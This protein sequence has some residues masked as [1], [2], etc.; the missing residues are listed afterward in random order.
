MDVI[1]LYIYCRYTADHWMYSTKEWWISRFFCEAW[2]ICIYSWM[3]II[4]YS[5]RAVAAE[6]T[7]RFPDPQRDSITNLVSNHCTIWSKLL[8]HIDCSYYLC[9]VDSQRST[10]CLLDQKWTREQVVKREREFLAIACLFPYTLFLLTFRQD[11]NH[12]GPIIPIVI[13]SSY[14]I[15]DGTQC[16][17]LGKQ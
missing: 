12:D 10:L 8:L 9:L 7:R 6:P 17:Q 14:C 4:L 11:G 2:W 15:L 13:A 3:I 16:S 5:K 1:F